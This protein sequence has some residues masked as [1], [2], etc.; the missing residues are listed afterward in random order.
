MLKYYP[1]NL[2]EVI[3]SLSR[4]VQFRYV[5]RDGTVVRF[6]ST[7]KI[8][9]AIGLAFGLAY[10]HDKGIVHQDFKPENILLDDDLYPKVTDFGLSR[11]SSGTHDPRRSEIMGTP[12]YCAPEVWTDATRRDK[13][14]DVYSYG[15]TLYELLTANKAWS[16]EIKL[17]GPGSHNDEYSVI[18][19][20]RRRVSN[21][22][23]PSLPN[24]I[25]TSW[26]DLVSD[27]WNKDPYWRPTM[28]HVVH[29]VTNHL[30][31]LVVG[32]FEDANWNE[33][34]DYIALMKRQK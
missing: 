25:P 14:T 34:Q 15:M 28:R 2:K 9:C 6:D 29:I 5:K 19:E 16:I 20:L 33:I 31:E 3:D 21:G 26:K 4:G 1:M 8:I 11:E 13:A 18:H 27:C 24:Y 23:R 17:P 12:L 32:R 7:K 10:L 30:D 22:D